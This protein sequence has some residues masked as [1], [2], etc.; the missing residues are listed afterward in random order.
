[1]FEAYSCYKYD[2]TG[3]IYWILA[4]FGIYMIILLH[5][6]LHISLLRKQEKEFIVLYN[7]E[8]SYIYIY[9]IIIFL[10]LM[11]IIF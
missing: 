3:V 5:Q 6:F 1:M 10:I 8:D 7:Y 4:I 2:S 11:I 9:L